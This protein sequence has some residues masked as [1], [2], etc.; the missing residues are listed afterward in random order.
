VSYLLD[1]NVFSEIRR[2]RNGDPHFKA[3]WSSRSPQEVY[4]SVLVLGE[5][6]RGI[7][8]IR[9]RDPVRAEHFERWLRSGSRLFSG[10]ILIV[11]ARVTDTWGRITSKRSLPV[12]DSLLA[13]TALSYDMTLVTRNTRDVRDTGVRF[14]D[15]F[16]A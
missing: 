14:L 10:R 9:H 3:W 5:V 12:I 8:K 2:G 6:R 16:A 13:A 1:T 7:Q 15:P 11:D 4:L